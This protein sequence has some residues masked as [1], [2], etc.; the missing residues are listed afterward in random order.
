MG[1]SFY[2]KNYGSFGLT[3]LKDQHVKFN[4]SSVTFAFKGKKGISHKIKLKNKKLATIIKKCRDVP[5]KELFQFYDEEDNPHSIDSGL[6]NN[7]IKEI[8]NSDFTAKDFRTWSGTVQAFLAFKSIGCCDTQTETKRRI[9]EALDIVSE[10]LGNTRAVCKKYYVHPLMLS[11]YENGKLEKY[12]KE[13]DNIEKSNKKEELTPEEKVV[14]KILE[15][16]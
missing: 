8:S 1:N 5:G 10:Q 11:L 15:S 16:N 4:G 2:E 3:T 9:V 7:Y 13:L 14:L 6:V 12:I